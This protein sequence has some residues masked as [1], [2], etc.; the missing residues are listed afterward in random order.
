[1]FFVRMAGSG[2]RDRYRRAGRI[3]SGMGVRQPRFGDGG[4]ENRG[5]RAGGGCQGVCSMLGWLDRDRVIV[6]G[7]QA[8]SILGWVCGN[9]ASTTAEVRTGGKG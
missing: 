2:P 6:I 9:L 3:Y 8:A 1:M 5:E 4:G 7:A